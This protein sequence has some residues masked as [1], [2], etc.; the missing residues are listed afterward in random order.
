VC[1]WQIQDEQRHSGVQQLRQRHGV[2]VDR[3]DLV[4][5]LRKLSR[6]YVLGHGSRYLRAMPEQF[7][8]GRGQRVP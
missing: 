7:A 8:L 3:G 4:D 5:G 6:E 2:A 1:G